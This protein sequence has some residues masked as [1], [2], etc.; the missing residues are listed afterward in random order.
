MK[1][2]ITYTADLS[3]RSIAETA[4]TTCLTPSAARRKVATCG[5]CL[6]GA[7]CDVVV[8]ARTRNTTTAAE[9]LALFTLPTHHALSE[10]ECN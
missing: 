5:M 1:Y 9:A 10:S 4:S 6:G 8:L 2:L 3:H 7:T